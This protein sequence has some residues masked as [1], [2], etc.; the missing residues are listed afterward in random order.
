MARLGLGFNPVYPIDTL[1]KFAVLAEKSG[2]ESVWLHESLY[3]HDAISYIGAVLSHTTKL[4]AASGC[5]NTVTRHPSVAAT[6]FATLSEASEGR[7]I[8][9]L[10]LGSF[11][12]LPKIGFQV[13]PTA[14]SRTLKRITEYA[15]ILRALLDGGNVNF[16]GEFFTVKD[17]KLEVKPQSKI[18]I[19]I[20]SL[21]QKTLRKVGGMADG[22]ILSPALSTLKE[23]ET[24]VEWVR[25]GVKPA[26]AFDI[27]SYMMTSV[28]EKSS[29]AT[30]AIR[31]FYFFVY[32][33]SEVIPPALLEPYDVTEA[34]LRPVKEAWK[35][36]NVPEAGSKIPEEVIEALT[37][38][39]TPEHCLQ[40]IEE[41]RSAGV[42]LPILMPIGDVTAAIEALAP[43]SQE[44]LP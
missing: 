30:K 5:I 34:K 14:T 43:M 41:Y 12:T 28:N 16:Q 18:P 35:K 44:V 11:P 9:G 19:Y 13:F 38:T 29:E 32:Q 36:G 33:V 26:A 15:T 21:S 1:V 20:A 27:V 3:Q 6:S 17:L 2:Y 42:E 7:V 25:S 23:T 39:G 4:K 24:K 8:L 40:R 22:V 31:N 37:V 10:G